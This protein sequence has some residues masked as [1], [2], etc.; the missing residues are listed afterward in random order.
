ME[1]SALNP[2]VRAA[3]TE[4]RDIRCK[5]QRSCLQMEIDAH[6]K[7]SVDQEAL[8]KHLLGAP[9]GAQQLETLRAEHFAGAK[10]LRA[11]QKA[12][13]VEHSSAQKASLARMAARRWDAK[14]HLASSAN[15]QWNFNLDSLDEPLLIETTSNGIQPV[16]AAAPWNTSVKFQSQWNGFAADDAQLIFVFLWQNPRQ[17][18]V[19]INIESSLLL[20]GH[21]DVYQG[22]GGLNKSSILDVKAGMSLL[23][24]DPKSSG[25]RILYTSPYASLVTKLTD[26][27]GLFGLG[28]WQV[29]GIS[30]SLDFRYDVLV[31]P[32]SGSVIIE[33][34]LDVFT[35]ADDNGFVVLDFSSGDFGV[36]CPGVAIAIIS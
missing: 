9:G 21:C 30:R 6:R 22:G 17:T 23:A 34:H 36:T 29:A 24:D 32:P 25:P 2:A 28:D 18:D 31:L 10:R 27:G 26:G 16:V 35:I 14:K 33:V 13:A 7:E 11:A 20:N 8:L 12:S 1:K 15:A 5:V 19:V 4:A 3:L